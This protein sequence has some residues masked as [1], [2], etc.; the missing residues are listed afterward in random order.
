MK[1]KTQRIAE[2]IRDGILTT[3]A[4]SPDGTVRPSDAAKQVL[5]RG[6]SLEKIEEACDRMLQS[7]TT[8]PWTELP[9][10]WQERLGFSRMPADFISTPVVFALADEQGRIFY[11]SPLH[12]TDADLNRSEYTIAE[13][14]CD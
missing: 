2:Y 12:C 9:V 7:F 13:F 8:L 11:K 4:K 14:L 10:E 5:L 1:T 6:P 3:L